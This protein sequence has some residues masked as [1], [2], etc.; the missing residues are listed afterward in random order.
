MDILCWLL[1]Y[2]GSMICMCYC[3]V[4]FLSFF[5]PRRCVFLESHSSSSRQ[6]RFS[7]LSCCFPAFL[8]IVAS[9]TTIH[10]ISDTIMSLG[11]VVRASSTRFGREKRHDSWHRQWNHERPMFHHWMWP[12][13]WQLRRLLSHMQTINETLTRRLLYLVSLLKASGR[14]AGGWSKLHRSPHT[15]LRSG[16]FCM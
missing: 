13:L 3:N 4:T 11:P 10:H 7:H 15:F 9:H 8:L 12:L 14:I 6:W 2:D 1:C 16:I 5:S